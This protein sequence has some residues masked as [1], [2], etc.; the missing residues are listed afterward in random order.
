MSRGWLRLAT[1]KG[2]R[3]KQAYSKVFEG[4]AL[5]HSQQ[6]PDGGSGHPTDLP[7]RGGWLPQIVTVL[8]NIQ[9]MCYKLTRDEL[10]QMY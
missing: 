3:L 7:S 8:V 10:E 9:T 5:S 4:V 6:R 1:D 2:N